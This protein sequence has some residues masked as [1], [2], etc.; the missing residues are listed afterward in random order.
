MS[1]PVSDVAV[2]LR[3]RT[4]VDFDMS[5]EPPPLLRRNINLKLE[6]ACLL[7]RT[8][9]IYPWFI[10]V[11]LERHRILVLWRSRF[12]RP[13]LIRRII[14]AHVAS[15][16]GIIHVSY[17]VVGSTRQEMFIACPTKFNLIPN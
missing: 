8:K 14:E 12:F 1:S 13:S 4:E 5:G 11:K 15:H 16:I 17:L 9:R 6:L 2:A 3:F 10:N 7:R